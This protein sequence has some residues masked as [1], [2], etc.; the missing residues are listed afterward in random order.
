MSNVTRREFLRRLA[1]AGLGTL[2][3]G[4]LLSA[5]GEQEVAAPTAHTVPTVPALLGIGHFGASSGMAGMGVNE[6]QK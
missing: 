6:L 2:A 4:W 5:C 3:S 1:A